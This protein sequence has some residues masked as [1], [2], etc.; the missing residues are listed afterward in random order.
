VESM[1]NRSEQ[2]SDELIAQPEDRPEQ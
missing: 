1:D 2:C